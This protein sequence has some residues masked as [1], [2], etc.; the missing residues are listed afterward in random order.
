MTMSV[1]LFELG[2]GV[3]ALIGAD[4]ETGIAGYGDTAPEALR[5]LAANLRRQ[6]LDWSAPELELSLGLPDMPCPELFSGN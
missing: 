3:C 5:D 6:G 4:C 1:R 2:L